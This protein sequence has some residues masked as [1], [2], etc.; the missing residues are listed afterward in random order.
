MA[1]CPYCGTKLEELTEITG[2]H[3]WMCPNSICQASYKFGRKTAQQS[4]E[5]DEG[6]SCDFT[7]PDQN[8]WILSD[9]EADRLST[10][11]R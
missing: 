6:D 1:N 8:P 3:Y 9:Q 2:Y 7:D 10:L 5:A 11:R 4:V